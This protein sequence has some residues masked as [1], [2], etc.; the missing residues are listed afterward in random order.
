M[1]IAR[2]EMLVNNW[3]AARGHV[4][5]AEMASCARVA[6]PLLHGSGDE[7]LAEFAAVNFRFRAI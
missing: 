4:N 3:F 1:G 6:L 7:G 2:N 5:A